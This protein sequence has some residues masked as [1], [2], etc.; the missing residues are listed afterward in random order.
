MKLGWPKRMEMVFPF[1][2]V[3]MKSLSRVDFPSFLEEEMETR[4]SILGWKIPWTEDPGGLQ[5]MEFQR[6]RHD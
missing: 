5:S 1:L 6:V 4:S 3:K 2:K